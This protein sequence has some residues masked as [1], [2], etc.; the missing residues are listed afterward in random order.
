M[1]K[2]LVDQVQKHGE[3]SV[4]ASDGLIPLRALDF[5]VGRC[6]DFVGSKS[7]EDIDREPEKVWS[8]QWDQFIAWYYKLVQDK[9]RLAGSALAIRVG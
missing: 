7:H 3:E 5:A 8:H 4:R 9:C 2:W 1:L 6:T